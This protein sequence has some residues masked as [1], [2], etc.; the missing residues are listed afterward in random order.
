MIYVSWYDAVEYCNWLSRKKGFAQAYQIDRSRRDP[1]NISKY[2]ELKWSVACDFS[3]NGYRLPTEAEWEYAARGGKYSEGY[4]YAGS[5]TASDVAWDAWNSGGKTH[6][7]SQKKPNELGIYD[8]TGNVY[9]WCWD[10]YDKHY[11]ASSSTTDPTGPAKAGEVWDGRVF[12]GGSWRDGAY[13]HRVTLRI[14]VVPT[15]RVRV[16]GF[17]LARTATR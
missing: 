6:P 1:K 7:V 4:E 10:W 12:R 8:M 13:M 3:A 17:R 11:Y 5:D 16:N 14:C 9:E 15:I 2:D